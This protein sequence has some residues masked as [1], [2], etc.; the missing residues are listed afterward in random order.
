MGDDVTPARMPGHD[1][2][3]LVVQTGRREE[4][5]VADVAWAAQ[6]YVDWTDD[7]AFALGGGRAL[8]VETARYWASRIELADG[9]IRGVMGADEYHDDVDDNVFTNAMARWNLRR[10]AALLAEVNGSTKESMGWVDLADGLADGWDA[11]AGH[12]EQFA[13]YDDLEPL[14]ASDVASPPFPAD[15]VLGRT[16]VRRS[17]LIK[18][19]DVVMAHHLV[20]DELR[21]GSLEP[22]LAYYE[23]RTSHGS[24]LSPAIHA[25]Q[26]ARAGQ[27]DRALDLLR[28]A[29]RLD[30]ED[31]TGTTAGGLH[32]AAMGGVWQALAHGFL[33]LRPR[34]G[35]LHVEPH[36]P[37]AW[38]G[39]ALRLRFGGQRLAVR[40]D[41]ASVS[42]ECERPL[43]VQVAGAAGTCVPP[44]TQYFLEGSSS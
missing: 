15:L 20:P 37:V 1:G 34:R 41:H 25:C 5:I 2:R 13:G 4:H 8:L 22:D 26:L 19:A 31:L 40:A 36:L 35:V 16:R 3:P 32:L 9:H 38:D 29:C 11:D 33:G 14:L 28:M 10:A 42:I 6:R 27:P 7:R 44:E 18:Q 43:S 21:P 12:H 23:P 39:L 17:Q 24:S 30:L